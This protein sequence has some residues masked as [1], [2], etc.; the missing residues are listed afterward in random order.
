MEPDGYIR[1]EASQKIKRPIPLLTARTTGMSYGLGNADLKLRIIMSKFQ[2]AQSTI[3]IPTG[4][5]QSLLSPG[6][7][8]VAVRELLFCV[9]EREHY[10]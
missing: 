8:F 10:L 6:T 4:M 7:D 1:N 3:C 2:S 5:F 9:T